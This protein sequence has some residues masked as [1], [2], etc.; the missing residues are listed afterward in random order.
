MTVIDARAN[1]S[2]RRYGPT[3][4]RERVTS[5]P[6]RWAV[7]T[8]SAMMLSFVGLFVFF[9]VQDIEAPYSSAL[10]ALLGVLAVTRVLA[11]WNLAFVFS[12][13]GLEIYTSVQHHWLGWREVTAI[14]EWEIRRQ[15]ALSMLLGGRHPF[16]VLRVHRKVRPPITIRASRGIDEHDLEILRTLALRNGVEWIVGEDFAARTRERGVW[17]WRSRG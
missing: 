8:Q 10:V 13:A 4:V 6:A 12:D 7:A 17:A 3:H 1:T 9:L 16:R 2:A 15:N 11:V 5:G 14:C